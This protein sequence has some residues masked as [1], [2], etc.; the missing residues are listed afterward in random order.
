MHS[1]VSGQCFH[2]IPSSKKITNSFDLNIVNLKYWLFLDPEELFCN[3]ESVGRYTY[4]LK[5]VYN[6]KR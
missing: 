2:A 4:R 1:Q 5:Y 3:K 6:R